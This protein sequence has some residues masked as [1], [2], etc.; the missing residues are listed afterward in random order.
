MRRLGCFILVFA[1]W[2]ALV[3]G[4]TAAKVGWDI[5][6][7]LAGLFFSALVTVFL[8]EIY[9]VAT[10]RFLNPRRWLWFILYLPYFFIACVRANLDVAY[11]VIHPEIPIKP[12]IIKVR[13]ILKSDIAKTIL[14]NSITLT[15]GTMS[16]DIDGQDLYIHWINVST[17]D[18]EEQ[19]KT[20]VGRFEKMLKEIFE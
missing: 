5:Q 19:T 18:A 12:G 16:V 4:A 14:A 13:T 6:D 1:I 9:P 11:R 3:W 20:I 2:L 17:F 10:K 15:P 7:V 8:S